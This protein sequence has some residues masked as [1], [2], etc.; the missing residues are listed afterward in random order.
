MAVLAVQIEASKIATVRKN[1][2][3]IG[4]LSRKMIF[5]ELVSAEVPG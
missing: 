3:V 4:S 5:V 1:C 2:L